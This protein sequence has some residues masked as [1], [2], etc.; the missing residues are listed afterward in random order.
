MHHG[1]YG[2]I[3]FSFKQLLK[4]VNMEQFVYLLTKVLSMFL[5]REK[6]IGVMLFAI[7]DNSKNKG[8]LVFD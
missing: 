5:R 4:A 6:I 2:D 7:K 3:L 1:T 8:P